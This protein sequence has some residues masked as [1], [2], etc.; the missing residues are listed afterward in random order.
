MF[1]V[2]RDEAVDHAV[3]RVVREALLDATGLVAA[4]SPHSGAYADP[5]SADVAQAVHE[6]RKRCKEVRGVCA[7]VGPSVGDGA[8]A[9]DRLCRNAARQLAP[10]RDAVVAQRWLGRLQTEWGVD[11]SAID[12]V[13]V[14]AEIGGA[15]QDPPDLE[16]A[17]LQ[18]ETARA[19]AR[20]WKLGS[21]FGA[22]AGGLE[23]TYRRGVD[24]LDIV[25]HGA[26]AEQ[27]HRWR[28]S[29]KQLWYQARL[30]QP[31]APSVLDP[32]VAQLDGIG[33][34]VGDHHDL[35]VL[36][37]AL[38]ARPDAERRRVAAAARDIQLDL[39][40]RATA[41]GARVYAE[42]PAAF[43]MRIGA[44]WDLWIEM[45]PDHTFG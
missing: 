9:V 5:A 8:R 2:E 11:T 26:G 24:R 14:A 13:A 1:R 34:S 28:S 25:V 4:M 18:L 12:P 6:V 42:T 44:Y 38:T 21:G 29:V 27:L 15:D 23:A 16:L 22:V 35:H 43:A 36:R 7:L 41:A 17:T 19:F 37:L 31:I 45:V 30:L 32:L 20:A 3:R 39:E 40:S 33:E 10:S